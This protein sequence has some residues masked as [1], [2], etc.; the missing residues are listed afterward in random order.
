MREMFKRAM[1]LVAVFVGSWALMA[2]AVKVAGR[3]VGWLP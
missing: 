1:A 3:V 2:G